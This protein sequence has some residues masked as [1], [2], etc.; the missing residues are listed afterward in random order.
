MCWHSWLHYS[1]LNVFASSKPS[2]RCILVVCVFQTPTYEELESTYL[3]SYLLILVS[4]SRVVASGVCFLICCLSQA[5]PFCVYTISFGLFLFPI[6]PR[7]LLSSILWIPF[8][9]RPHDHSRV[10]CAHLSVPFYASSF[11]QGLSFLFLSVSSPLHISETWF[12]FY[13]LINS[14]IS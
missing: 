10:F 13:C 5:V 9:L 8:S 4:F 14:F 6:F 7:F 2:Q 12:L 11:L 1:G 3:Y